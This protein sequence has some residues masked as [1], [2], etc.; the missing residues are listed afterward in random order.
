MSSKYSIYQLS[1]IAVLLSVSDSLPQDAAGIVHLP[2]LVGRNICLGIEPSPSR[3][4]WRTPTIRME[5]TLGSE[6]SVYEVIFDDSDEIR[7]DAA[8]V[9]DKS[10]KG[11]PSHSAIWDREGTAEFCLASWDK[12]K[13]VHVRMKARYA[14]APNQRF[15]EDS[16]YTVAACKLGEHPNTPQYGDILKM[17]NGIPILNPK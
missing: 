17:D 16:I 5:R 9:D 6:D 3:P 11:L 12:G 4:S 15:V 1:F 10:C 13:S 14:G 2:N 8:Y 7:I